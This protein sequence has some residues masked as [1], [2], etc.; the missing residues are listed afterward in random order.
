[1]PRKKINIVIGNHKSIWGIDYILDIIVKDLLA[2]FSWEINNYPKANW[3][4]LYIEDFHDKSFVQEMQNTPGKH[5]LICTEFIEFRGKNLR[6]NPSKITLR[7]LRSDIKLLQS[8][9]NI[10]DWKSCFRYVSHRTLE[11]LG[12]SKRRLYFRRRAKALNKLFLE[13][14]FDFVIQLHP[15]V[16]VPE[17]IQG[18]NRNNTLNFFP[19]I[20]QY[21]FA[22]RKF[23]RKKFIT[24]GSEN[25]YRQLIIRKMNHELVD[26]IQRRENISKEEL[27]L[28]NKTAVVDLYIKNRLDWTFS[29]PIRIARSISAGMFVCLV[30]NTDFVHPIVKV[31]MSIE[32]TKGI[33]LVEDIFDKYL[34]TLKQEFTKYENWARAQN[35]IIAKKL[36][37]I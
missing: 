9:L 15:S 21:K 7:A 34:R 37:E 19:Q 10:E 2:D 3:I 22:E 33:W 35:A 14:F 8:S 18:A 36:M 23:E 24:Q 25:P 16:G 13:S 6:L 32:S 17:K 4:N 20:G 5:I 1:M 26:K 29:S 30:D 27:T 12:L 31:C 11:Y 28:E